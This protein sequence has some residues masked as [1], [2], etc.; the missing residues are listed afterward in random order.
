[1]VLACSSIRKTRSGAAPI[2]QIASRSPAPEYSRSI[3]NPPAPFS[4]SDQNLAGP[5]VH[6]QR[7]RETGFQY[8]PLRL[9]AHPVEFRDV[10]FVALVQVSPGQGVTALAGD[11]N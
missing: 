7:R 1:M 2:W 4:R 11:G 5:F 10:R 6:T 9:L 3:T 8:A